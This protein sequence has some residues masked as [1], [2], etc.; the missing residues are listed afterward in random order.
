MKEKQYITIFFNLQ[1]KDQ[2]IY[3]AFDFYTTIIFIIS[4]VVVAI[5]L[6][7]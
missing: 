6:G 1:F 5:C 3:R 2:N 7:T 4:M